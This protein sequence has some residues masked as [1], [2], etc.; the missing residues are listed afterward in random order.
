[1]EPIDSDGVPYHYYNLDPDPQLPPPYNP[2]AQ[3]NNRKMFTTLAL[4]AV[5]IVLALTAAIGAFVT[6]DTKPKYFSQAKYDA[7]VSAYNTLDPTEQ[8]EICEAM[9]RLTPDE[10]LIFGSEISDGDPIEA[11]AMSDS[12]QVFMED[13]C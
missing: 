2:P 4:I 1:M 11:R 3:P 13:Y 7:L 10:A 9:M 8:V 6:R 12:M 5:S